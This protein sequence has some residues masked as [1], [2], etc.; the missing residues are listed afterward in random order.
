[1]G[2]FV[3]ARFSSGAALGASSRLG[4]SR[5]SV[6][7]PITRES[8][9][10][11]TSASPPPLTAAPARQTTP[12]AVMRR[13]H[14]KAQSR[15]IEKHDA[16]QARAR[17]ARLGR[18]GFPPR[19]QKAP[20]GRRGWLSLSRRPIHSG[21]SIDTEDHRWTSL[22]LRHTTRSSFERRRCA[23]SCMATTRRAARMPGSGSVSRRGSGRC[24]APTRSPPS[25]SSRSRPRS[26]SGD[27]II[28]VS[29]VAQTFIQL[30]LLPVI[31]VGQNVQAAASDARAE[32]D[33]ETLTAVHALTVAVHEINEQ[34]SQDPRAAGQSRLTA[35]AHFG[36]DAVFEWAVSECDGVI[37]RCGIKTP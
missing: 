21:K 26:S 12:T 29:W 35:P 30:V 17:P 11:H 14:C 1:M 10:T 9:V 33:H 5:D 28:I 23:N 34:Q 37:R 8:H 27:L 13:F 32:A 7:G 4:G 36:G 16:G 25:R 6:C 19:S 24:G 31:I 2:W 3:M 22:V 20:C 18:A 15:R